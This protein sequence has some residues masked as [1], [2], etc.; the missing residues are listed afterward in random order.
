[1]V[2][3]PG[4]AGSFKKKCTRLGTKS[5]GDPGVNEFHQT[6]RK[7]ATVKTD[8]NSCII[9]TDGPITRFV[10]WNR[11]KVLEVT[12]R[13]Y[14]PIGWFTVVLVRRQGARCDDCSE[15]TGEYNFCPNGSLMCV[16]LYVCL[17]VSRAIITRINYS[18]D[19]WSPPPY[20]VKFPFV[21]NTNYMCPCAEIVSFYSHVL[22]RY[23]PLARGETIK[24]YS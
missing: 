2:P 12:S 18:L 13:S 23:S 11:Q 1:M 20:H 15:C 17:F 8:Q 22:I 24:M 14:T 9:R 10:F 3:R 7:L 16:Y 21:R 6:V 19:H 4:L 5:R